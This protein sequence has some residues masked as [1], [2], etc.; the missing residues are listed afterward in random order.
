MEQL[1]GIESSYLAME[2]HAMP[3]VVTAVN[4]YEGGDKA[5]F[6]AIRQS[7]LNAVTRFP[8]FRRR[9]LKV[10][11]ALDHPYW[12]EDPD[13]DVDCHLR[14][15]ALPE[16]G[17][18]HQ[19]Y[20]QLARLQALPMHRDRPLWQAF[21]ITG[22][23]SL[24][25][26]PKGSFALV[27]RAHRAIAD[28]G[29]LN[30]L[31]MRMHTFDPAAIADE[32]QLVCTRDIRPGSGQ[33]LLQAL[34]NQGGRWWRSRQL[35]QQSLDR[36]RSQRETDMPE[37]PK[38]VATRFN[39]HPSSFRVVSH[40]RL[41]RS[42]CQAMRERVPG[43]SLCDVMLTLIGG[44]MR[45]YLL[46]KGELPEASLV[47]SMPQ[48]LVNELQRKDK[49]VTIGGNLRLALHTELAS[50]LERLRRVSEAQRAAR[51]HDP[52]AE[53][54]LINGAAEMIS[55][56]FM[57]LGMQGYLR[58]GRYTPYRHHT[59]VEGV[60]GSDM[61]LYFGYSKLLRSFALAP[62]LPGASLTHCLSRWGNELTLAI[63]A[64][65]EALPDPDAYLKAL[66]DAWL[67]ME[68]CLLPQA[69]ERAADVISDDYAQQA[70]A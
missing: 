28:N 63:N 17:N 69:S 51:A 52:L 26:L 2:Q 35:L 13:F 34:R 31:L 48:S 47:A 19:F 49:S 32:S 42:G 56:L 46:H 4:I 10:P 27:V 7:F 68:D 37:A 44:G 64:C 33:L 12:I 66:Q 1:T 29:Q 11:S 41:P 53:Q 36:Y 23:D 60:R 59:F 14:Q 15:M 58:L 22:L 50:P 62:L 18:W 45:N 30:A 21:V 57:R 20:L 5:D 25:G 40:L 3:L 6:A 65:R 16:P 54:S 38:T 61:P 8:L 39:Q 67:D 9:L 70:S 55:P 24:S 43:S